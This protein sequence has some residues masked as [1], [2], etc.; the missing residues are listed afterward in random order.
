MSLADLPA[1]GIAAAVAAGEAS[2]VEVMTDHLDRIEALDPTVNAIVARRPR[3]ELL[4]EVAGRVRTTVKIAH[5]DQLDPS[6]PAVLDEL[7]SNEALHTAH[8]LLGI[9]R[10]VRRL[11]E[12][13]PAGPPRAKPGR[14]TSA[15]RRPR[16]R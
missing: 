8:D 11:A 5:L 13:E 14:R 16:G 12:V 1:T 4:A 7:D 15:P 6:V 3:E 2:C 10:E 9:A